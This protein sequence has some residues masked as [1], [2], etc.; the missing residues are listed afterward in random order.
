MV[1]PELHSTLGW[2][3]EMAVAVEVDGCF[4]DSVAPRLPGG[5]VAGARAHEIEDRTGRVLLG[6]GSCL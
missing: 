4:S 1:R 5:E 2:G 3:I 6:V